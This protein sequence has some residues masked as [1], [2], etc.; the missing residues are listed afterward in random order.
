[1]ADTLV[2]GIDVAKDSFQ[3]ASNPSG[4]NLSLLND[5]DG[6]Q[7]LLDTLQAYRITLVVL[8][9]TGGYERGLVAD[10]LQA[11]YNVV[12]ANPRQVRDFARGMGQLAKTDP[13]DASVL[14]KFGRIVAP[15]P[16]PQPTEQTMDLAE[17]VSRRQQLNGLL[18]QEAN[19]LPMARHIKV[20]KS[21]QKVIRT[22]EQQIIDLDKLIGDNIQSDDGLQR[23]D[24]ILQSFK[25]IGPG[26]SAMLLS[27]LPELGQLNRQEIAALAGLA[28]W[29]VQSGKWA[30][31][32]RVWGGRKEVRTMLYMAALSAIR[33]NQVIQ[34]FYQRLISKGKKF[35]VALTAC[36]RKILV[37]LN[38]L[39]RNDSLWL[40]TSIKNT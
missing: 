2:V 30:G 40:P 16:R 20:R 38:T 12:V 5:P 6:R 7:K 13:I 21:L 39:L 19:R 14:A 28:P 29:D 9:A 35:K 11:H 31:Q 3:V 26:T 34:T 4:L 8:E 27:H 1:M 33:W 10:L 15:K 25:G 17:L 23:K 37:I 24:E 22:L 18:T 32:S 36:M